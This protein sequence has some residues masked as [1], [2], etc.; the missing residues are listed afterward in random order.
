MTRIWYKI[1]VLGEVLQIGTAQFGEEKYHEGVRKAS[2]FTRFRL[3]FVVV[4][5]EVLFEICLNFDIFFV[6]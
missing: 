5:I 2:I 1:L 4:F 3:C 6:F